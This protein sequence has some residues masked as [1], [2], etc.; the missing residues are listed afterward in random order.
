MKTGN[1]RKLLILTMLIT[2][3]SIFACSGVRDVY[4]VSTEAKKSIT[5]LILPDDKPI[6]KKKI[7]ITPVI[8]RAGISTSL[9]EQTRQ[10]CISYLSKDEYLVISTLKNWNDSESAFVQKEYGAVINPAYIKTAGEMGMNILLA[11][12]IHPLEITEKRTGIWPFRKD[13]HNV[14]VSVSINA[15]NT[16]DGTLLVYKDENENIDFGK[17]NEG[18]NKEWVPDYNILKDEISSLIKKLCSTVIDRLRK[19]PWQSRADIDGD[20]L[21]IKAGKDIGIDQNT[22]F[23]LYQKGSSY[24]S[25]SGEEYYTLGKKIGE[26]GIKTVSKNRAVLKGIKIGDYKDIIFVRAKRD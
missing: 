1:L 15:V 11:C 20:N 2:M 16:V 7:L 23:E 10:E 6:L 3:T 25:F 14:L 26:T 12:I 19:I 4:E 21:V 17:V 8:D 24:E 13:S 22:I 18:E 5:D 9:S